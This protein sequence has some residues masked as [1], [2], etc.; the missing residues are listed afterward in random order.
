[1][2]S[3]VTS[4]SVGNSRV[5]AAGRSRGSCPAEPSFAKALDT[6]ALCRRSAAMAMCVHFPAIMCL[7]TIVNSNSSAGT[8]VRNYLP[9]TLAFTLRRV[10]KVQ[11]SCYGRPKIFL[12]KIKRLKQNGKIDITVLPKQLFK[13][14]V[15]WRLWLV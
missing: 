3:I 10:V 2:S 14:N 13:R 4:A 6:K 7:P 5:T 8:K 11:G 15:E 9:F 1:M 12:L